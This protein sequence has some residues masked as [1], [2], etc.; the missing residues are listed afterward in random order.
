M[1]GGSVGF[2]LALEDSDADLHTDPSR[3]PDADADA[4]AR[5]HAHAITD[6]DANTDTNAHLPALAWRLERVEQLS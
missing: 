4:Y 6:Q 3:L 1:Q 2:C 5:S